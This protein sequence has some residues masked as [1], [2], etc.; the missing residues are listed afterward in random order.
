LS[1]EWG[2]GQVTEGPETV[3]TEDAG[4]REQGKGDCDG[5]G[6]EVKPEG[7]IV[8]LAQGE[9][10]LSNLQRQPS[11]LWNKIDD[12]VDPECRRCGRYAETGKHVALVC[13]HGEAVGKMGRT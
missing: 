11:S 2:E 9:S 13:T 10:P 8:W 7:E 1:E 3:M 4:E 6:R 5:K 12:T